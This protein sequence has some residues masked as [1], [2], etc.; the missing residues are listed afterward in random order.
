MAPEAG[1]EKSAQLPW[2]A[3]RCLGGHGAALRSAMRAPRVGGPGRSPALG[4]DD[5][6]RH[7][8]TARSRGA[9]ALQPVAA[10]RR[11][12]SMCGGWKP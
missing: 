7:V 4:A 3:A 10:C 5:A 9:A 2:S 12:T 1:W 6:P 8:Q 11:I